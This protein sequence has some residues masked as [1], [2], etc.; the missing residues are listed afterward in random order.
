MMHSHFLYQLLAQEIRLVFREV[1]VVLI[2]ER[3]V[4]NHQRVQREVG[5]FVRS[6]IDPPYGTCGLE[7]ETGFVGK[8][9]CEIIRITYFHELLELPERCTQVVGAEHAAVFNLRDVAVVT[10]VYTQIDVVVT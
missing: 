6:G 8:T 3:G 7:A 4:H 9:C 5:Q 2:T 1:H 10:A